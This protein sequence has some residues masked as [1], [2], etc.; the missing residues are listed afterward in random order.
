VTWREIPARSLLR[1]Q[2]RVDSWFLS[3]CGMNLYRG[4]G[5]DCAYCDGRAEKYAVEGEF[6]AEVVVKVNAVELLR[7]ELAPTPR[8]RESAPSGFVLLGGGVGDSYQPAE[9]RYELA[10]RALELL[11]EL[12]RPVHV[13]TKS[14]LVE[15]DLDLL[16]RIHQRS[17]AIVSMSFSSVDRQISARFEPGVP[18]PAKRLEVLSR[19]RRAGIPV[20]MYLM[21]VLPFLTDTEQ[22]LERTMEQAAEAGVGFIVFGGLTLRP[23]RQQEHF[24]SVLRGIRPDLEERCR[25]LYPG[26]KWGRAAGGHFAALER[27]FGALAR[28]HR[29]PPRMPPGLYAGILNPADRAVVTLKHLDHLLRLRGERSSFGEAART[30][31]RQPELA[32]EAQQ[33]LF[34]G[35]G[36]GLAPAAVA[37]LD[38]LRRTGRSTLLESLLGG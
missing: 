35:R 24:L 20:G 28:R 32:C 12:G 27:R 16:A 31:A 25:R 30:V 21:P 34:P 19:F 8:R 29:V 1:R 4:C 17:R 3:R 2:K 23:G 26:D 36:A 6:G 15:R 33:D 10:R 22:M 37:V 13:L 11:L 9:E 7:R 5:H 18:P 14:A 38:E